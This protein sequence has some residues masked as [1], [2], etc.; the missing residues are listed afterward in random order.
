[1]LEQVSI[2]AAIGERHVRLHVVAE[3]AYYYLIA[4][5]FQRRGN[6]LFY[7]IAVRPRCDAK[8][9]GV[10]ITVRMSKL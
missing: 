1:M 6:G 2:D 5:L 3:F 10:R 4:F 7:H 9:D 8:Y